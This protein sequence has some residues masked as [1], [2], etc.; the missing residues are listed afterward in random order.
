[1]SGERTVVDA[2]IEPGAQQVL[3]GHLRPLLAPL[4]EFRA[5]VP[6]A[7]FRAEDVGDQLARGQQQM[8]VG[9][10]AVIAMEGEVHHHPMRDKA[11][12]SEIAQPRNLLILRQLDGQ[13]DLDL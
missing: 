3:V 4:H 8:R 5:I 13:P 7:P 2:D 10:L 9:V 11:P 12:L 1:M 6:V